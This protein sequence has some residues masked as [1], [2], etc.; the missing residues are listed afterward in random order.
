MRCLNN[1]KGVIHINSNDI[2]YITQEEMYDC[3]KKLVKFT[4]MTI[5]NKN[6][7]VLINA[8]TIYNKRSAWIKY[9]EKRTKEL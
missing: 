4:S 9:P 2:S 3:R 7:K 6:D 1:F 5:Y 8:D